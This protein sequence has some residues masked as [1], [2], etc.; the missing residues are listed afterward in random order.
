MV[1]LGDMEVVVEK[2]TESSRG[3]DVLRGVGGPFRVV[4]SRQVT[5]T[6]NS[7]KTIVPVRLPLNPCEKVVVVVKSVL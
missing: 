2:P 3:C 5:G 6:V 7:P 1:V 4:E